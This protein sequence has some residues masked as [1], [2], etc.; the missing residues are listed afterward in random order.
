M[1][2]D[3][4]MHTVTDFIKHGKGKS[5]KAKANNIRLDHR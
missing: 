4:D 3:N 5:N 2:N 1:N